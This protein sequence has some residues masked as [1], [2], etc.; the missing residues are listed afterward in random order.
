MDLKGNS[1]ASKSFIKDNFV[2]IA[3][4]A[5]PVLMI[6]FFMLATILPKSMSTPPA[7]DFLFNVE[8]YGSIPQD[9]ITEL[10]V[11]DGKLYVRIK[12]IEQGHYNVKKIYRYNARNQTVSKVP[13]ALPTDTAEAGEI[14]VTETSGLTLSSDT[15][16]PDGYTFRSSNNAHNGLLNELFVGGDYRSNYFLTK[17]N[18]SW[19]L[20]DVERQTYYYNINFIGWIVG[21]N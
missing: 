1:M 16:A 7:H 15:T 9:F 21:G 6:V 5:L 14:I 13:F 19:K 2:L 12:K 10:V 11:H 17:G 3:G 4:L 8:E 18:V 20:P